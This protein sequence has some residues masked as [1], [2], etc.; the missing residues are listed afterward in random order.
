MGSIQGLRS[1]GVALRA[2]EDTALQ[3]SQ[4][5]G[6]V[7]K[8]LGNQITGI[9]DQLQGV[10]SERTKAYNGSMVKIAQ[11]V[12]GKGGLGEKGM[13]WV[14]GLVGLVFDVIN[15]GFDVS[16]VATLIGSTADMFALRSSINAAVYDYEK[17]ASQLGYAYVENHPLVGS[18]SDGTLPK[19]SNFVS[20][21]AVA[22]VNYRNAV[23]PTYR[24]N[25]QANIAG[26][27]V[28]QSY[29]GALRKR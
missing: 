25:N 23:M 29:I 5:L 11:T 16:A 10:I 2:K 14:F 7:N 1:E 4:H 13:N 27:T 3:I 18:S 17:G 22:Q 21:G 8:S 28:T 12:N 6:G 20:A 9:I 19:G 15:G 26:G 24:S